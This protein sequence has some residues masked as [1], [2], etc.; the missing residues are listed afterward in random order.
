MGLPQSTVTIDPT[1]AIVPVGGTVDF[2]A[3]GGDGVGEYVW[4][5]S[6]AGIGSAKTVQFDFAGVYQVHVY[7]N[8]DDT[9]DQSNTATST[10]TVF[11][12]AVAT[13]IFNPPGGLYTESQVVSITT[14][15]PGAAIRY[16][17]DGSTPTG[18]HGFIYVS[19]FVVSSPKTIK[20]IGVMSGMSN[21]A[22]AEVS[23]NISPPPVVTIDATP[24][25]GVAPLSTIV[26]W[27]AT[28]ATSVVVSGPGLSSAQ[29]SGSRQFTNLVLGSYTFSIMA[30]NDGGSTTSQITV[31]ALD[32]EID[33]EITGTKTVQFYDRTIYRADSWLWEFGDGS[34]STEQN[35]I[36]TYGFDGIFVVKLTAWCDDK[37]SVAIHT[38]SISG[39]FTG[40]PLPFTADYDQLFNEEIY[41]PPPY[42]DPRFSPQPDPPY[43]NLLGFT[44]S[45]EGL[46]NKNWDVCPYVDWCY[47]PSTPGVPEYRYKRRWV[48]YLNPST[49][50]WSW[51]IGSA[52]TPLPSILVPQ[53]SSYFLDVNYVSLSFALEGDPYIAFQK[54]TNQVQ[55]RYVVGGLLVT[56]TFPGFAPKLFSECNIQP[57]TVLC[58]MIVYYLKDDGKIYVRFQREN[59]SVEHPMVKP[60]LYGSDLVVITKIDDIRD[61]DVRRIYVYGYTLGQ[62]KI[63]LRSAQ[64]P[65]FPSDTPT[66]GTVPPEFSSQYETLERG[67]TSPA[68]IEFSALLL[69]LEEGDHSAPEKDGF[70]KELTL[71]SGAYQFVDPQL[72]TWSTTLVSG[73]TTVLVNP[74]TQEVGFSASATGTYQLK[75]EDFSSH[76]TTF[77]SGVHSIRVE[78][79]T[80][81]ATL[82]QGGSHSRRVEQITNTISFSG[83]HQLRVE[84]ITN[85]IE[86]SGSHSR[87]V[88]TIVSRETLDRGR[89]LVRVE[90]IRAEINLNGAN[91]RFGMDTPG[92]QVTTFMSGTQSYGPDRNQ[93]TGTSIM[94]FVEGSTTPGSNRGWMTLDLTLDR[95]THS[96]YDAQILGY[97]YSL[98]GGSHFRQPEQLMSLEFGFGSGKH[99]MYPVEAGT[100]LVA[101][102]SGVHY[103]QL[104]TFDYDGSM[105]NVDPEQDDRWDSTR[106]TW[107]LDITIQPDIA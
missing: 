26:S 85:R 8:A 75:L 84:Q 46:E 10:V 50:A 68:V 97:S 32:N 98:D 103:F 54:G 101:F 1:T 100:N 18:S 83:S 9:Y 107:D 37:P 104:F 94:T 25:V 81:Q 78:K 5:G 2:T 88:E 56:K 14:A 51:G 3:A 99:E 64:Y 23:Y 29:F 95:G 42:V 47:G 41:Q 80:Q 106:R 16:T 43:A 59:F 4:T 35:P 44:D 72:A 27:S 6:A 11:A 30:F 21:S 49:K 24:S 63:L 102:N 90:A 71:D 12:P 87:R 62:R 45:R 31:S 92:I 22:L 79:M 13:P 66:N 53:P 82:E 74:A 19:P 67:Y 36:H 48:I 65:I 33:Y 57:A 15:T 69:G 58:D 38:I 96:P 7:R 91:H 17:L 73:A 28:N 86:L 60:S 77:T 55:V 20:A 52:N 70:A 34:T 93:G 40:D 39:C 105:P 61:N 89:H 76:R